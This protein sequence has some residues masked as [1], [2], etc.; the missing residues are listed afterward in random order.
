M[1]VWLIRRDWIRWQII[2]TLSSKSKKLPL[3][4]PVEETSFVSWTGRHGLFEVVKE[5]RHSAVHRRL[6]APWI[7]WLSCWRRQLM[8]FSE[9]CPVELPFTGWRKIRALRLL[10]CARPITANMYRFC[11]EVKAR[12]DRENSRTQSPTPQKAGCFVI[13]GVSS[14]KR[15]P[16]YLLCAE[17]RM[18][19]CTICSLGWQQLQWNYFTLVHRCRF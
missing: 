19:P 2:G 15:T 1:E 9:C 17:N 3:R 14:L 7:A 10:C 8:M 6:L 13:Y 16:W 11:F 12:F 5:P 18:T 4:A